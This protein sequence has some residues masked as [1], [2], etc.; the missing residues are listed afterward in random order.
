MRNGT[1]KK[2][3]DNHQEDSPLRVSGYMPSRQYKEMWAEK[4]A[5]ARE[6]DNNRKLANGDVFVRWLDAGLGFDNESIAVY[7]KAEHK[8][9]RDQDPARH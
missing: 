9:H 3:N 1:G 2:N 6:K 4:L 5:E 7:T 8:R